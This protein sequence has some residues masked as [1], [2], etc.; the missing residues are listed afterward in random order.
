M[1]VTLLSCD[2]LQES[3]GKPTYTPLADCISMM[4]NTAKSLN[5]TLRFI[6]RSVSGDKQVY[7]VEA[8]RESGETVSSGTIY[9]I[10]FTFNE[11]S[12][13]RVSCS[14]SLERGGGRRCQY[15]VSYGLVLDSY[16]PFT[17]HVGTRPHTQATG[18]EPNRAT[19]YDQSSDTTE[20]C[21]KRPTY[22]WCAVMVQFSSVV[23]QF[24]LSEICLYFQRF[25]HAFIL[26]E[27]CNR[28][29]PVQFCSSA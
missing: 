6:A 9:R 7:E 15:F 1:N 16:T 12:C 4:A 19:L 21:W 10:L 2:L 23:A 5:I 26:S 13:H 27:I 22:G 8:K 3:C 28:A 25:V 29:G 18:H 24:I 20:P 11:V 14:V 17:L